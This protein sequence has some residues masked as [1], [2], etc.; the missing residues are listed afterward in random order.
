[1]ATILGI[2]EAGRGPIIGPMVMA[3]VMMEEKDVEKLV[4]LGV[5]DSKLLNPAKREELFDE[6]KRL[7]K[8]FRIMIVGVEEI[9]RAV[10]SET[11]MNLNV[12]EI[13]KAAHIVRRLCPD[14]VIMD[15]PSRNTAAV[16]EQLQSFVKKDGIH[17]ICKNKADVDYPIVGA[18]SILAK[19]MRDREIQKIKRK[20]GIDCGSGY[21]SDPFT[22]SFFR[23]H[24]D[25]FPIFRK[26][27]APYRSL[28]AQKGQSSLKKFW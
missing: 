15:A 4:R 2:D 3:G 5:K 10:M 9:D 22:N 8:D 20:Y 14:K 26:S 7:A 17:I 25:K 18:A 13:K 1:M 11:D 28:V 19:V 23:E 6:I 16:T 27:W 12:L 21:L 24:F